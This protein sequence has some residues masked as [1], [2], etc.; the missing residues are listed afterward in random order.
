MHLTVKGNVL[1]DFAAVSFEGGAE[2]VDVDAAENCHELVGDAGGKAAEK[3]VVAAMFAPAA[4]DVVTLFE[5]SE[6]VRDFAGVM[7]QIAVHG[8]DEVALGVIKASGE[9]GGLTKVAAEFDDEDTAIYG[10]DLFKKAV[11]PV[12]RAI[13]DEDQL[14]GFSN[15]LHNG[16]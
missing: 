12:A 9:S 13:V 14:E 2:V 6:E 1:D 16:L 15:L 4:D 10:G 8:K 3:K 11:G 5:L 7:L